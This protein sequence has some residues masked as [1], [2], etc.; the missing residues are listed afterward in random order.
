MLK[1]ESKALLERNEDL[2][3]ALHVMETNLKNLCKANVELTV[4]IEDLRDKDVDSLEEIEHLNRQNKRIASD[5]VILM[6]EVERYKYN[7]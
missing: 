7:K 5:N 6:R 4:T 3:N 2:E 1:V